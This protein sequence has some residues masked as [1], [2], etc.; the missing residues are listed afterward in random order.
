MADVNKL[1][2]QFASGFD[3]RQLEGRIIDP[4]GIIAEGK[5]VPGAIILQRNGMIELRIRFTAITD[6]HA[7]PI[8]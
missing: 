5:E 8:P 6:Q 2:E 7:H 4:L 1:I 3:Y